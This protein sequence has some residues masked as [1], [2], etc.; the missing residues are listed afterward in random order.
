MKKQKTR[1]KTEQLPQGSSLPKRPRHYAAEILAADVEKRAEM[2]E[3]VPDHLK[4]IVREHC[5]TA[6]DMQRMK[7]SN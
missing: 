2:F 1:R 4:N 3:S 7:R 5:Y 6:R